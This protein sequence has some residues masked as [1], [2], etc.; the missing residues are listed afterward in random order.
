MFNAFNTPQF[1][2]DNIDRS[3]YS[4]FVACGNA[5]CSAT[6]NT[7]TAVT[8]SNGNTVDPVSH[9]PIQ[10]YNGNFGVATRT[11]GAREIQ[12]AIKFYF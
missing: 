12:Y 6:N 1:R 9:R 2:G 3:F 7:I 5:A 10:P 4:G 8:D 11:R